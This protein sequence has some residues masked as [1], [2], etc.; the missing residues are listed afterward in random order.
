MKTLAIDLS[1]SRGSIALL[2]ETDVAAF[3][4]W[5]NDRKNSALFFGQLQQIV[6]RC[7]LPD[8]IIVGLGPGSYAGTRIAVSTAI[9]L[10]ATTRC[11]L[12]GYP[13]V[14]A[15][16][17]DA[18]DYA[19]IGDARRNSFF[20]VRISNRAVAGEFELHT[21]AELEDRIAGS[22]KDFPIVTSD[23]LP[24]FETRVEQRFPS[25][26][27]LGELA[28]D[29]GRLFYRPPLEPIYL[30]EPNVTIPKTIGVVKQV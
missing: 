27:V 3:E 21:A 18:V 25:A 29:A 23:L 19:V 16:D 15:I 6:Q 13:S 30:R 10:A 5:P 11:E 2:D 17:S 9:G 7:G 14:A 20:F 22:D 28:N 8:R 12:L 1:T 26:K 24:Q 4:H